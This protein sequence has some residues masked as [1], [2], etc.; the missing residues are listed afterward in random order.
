MTPELIEDGR[1]FPLLAWR[2]AGEVTA[3][4]TAAVGGGLGERR[5]VINAQ[6]AKDYRRHDLAAHGAELAALAGLSGAGVVMFTAADVRAV[7]SA[8]E[9]GV[10]ADATVGVTLPTWAA[11]ADDPVAV[12]APGTI[13]V[14]VQLP[15][16]LTASALLNALCTATEAKSQALFEAGVPGTGTASDAVTVVCPV[17]GPAEEFAGPR[18]VWGARLARAVHAAV[19]DGVRP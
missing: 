19:R 17:A 1:A 4:S 5:W 6:V 18:S 14:V 8:A 13:N 9:H 10:R 16:R 2:F 12:P 3:A 11:A 7:R 15:V